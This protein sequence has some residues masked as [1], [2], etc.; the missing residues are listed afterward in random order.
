MDSTSKTIGIIWQADFYRRPLRDDRGQSLWEL[1][2]CDGHGWRYQTFCPQPE[3]NSNWLAAQLQMAAGENLP[4][5]LE[6]FRPQSLSLLRLAGEGLGINVIPTRRTPQLKGWLQELAIAYPRDP[7]YTCE[8]YEPVIVEQL[9]PLPMPENLW[10]EQWRFASLRAGDLVR[11]FGDRPLRVRS[12]PEDL[13]PLKL[14]LASTVLIPGVI[15]DGGKQS[16]PLARW[17]ESTQPVSLEY[18]AGQ[19]DGLLLQSGLCDRWVIVTF[20]DDEVRQAAQTFAVRQQL[21]KGLHFLLVQPDNSGMTYTGF[22]LLK[23]E[24]S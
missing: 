12:L 20:K 23:K 1:L 4:L 3:A 21:A 7:H 16:L 13:L 24:K 9:P 5:A 22:W 11:E 2:L 8:P 14:G 10:G 19:P 15:I 6:V 18:I 17:L